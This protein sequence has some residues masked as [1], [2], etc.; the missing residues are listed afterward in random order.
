MISPS[1][2]ISPEAEV[3]RDAAAGPFAV[4]EAGVKIGAGCVIGAHAVIK[5]GCVLAE[6]V[7]VDCHAVI[8][9]LPQDLGFKPGTP[10]GV[11]IGAG[12]V[13]RE[14]VTVSRAT[15]PEGWTVIGERAYLMA[16]AHAAHDCVIGADA[17]LA[18]NVMLA[19][20]VEVG[21]HCFLG[22]GAAIHQHVRAGESVMLSGLSGVGLDVAPYLTCAGRN[23]V[24]G[25][26]LVGLKRRGFSREVIG[27][28]KRCYREVFGR[29]GKMPEIAAAALRD[30]LARTPEARLFLEFFT[31]PSRRGFLRPK[32]ARKEN[33][34]E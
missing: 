8:G 3:A 9:G 34:N 19:G 23:S 21:P 12:A 31:L 5:K 6:N 4:I 10:S 25:F 20:H 1:A 13:L 32:Q 18:N 16:Y 29:K 2:E 17:V 26:N 28:L 33:G 22:G 15:K 7:T 30:G 11:K 24:S 14:G 27:E